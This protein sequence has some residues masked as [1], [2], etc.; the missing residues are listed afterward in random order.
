MQLPKQTNT[1]DC[2]LYMLT[3]IDELLSQPLNRLSQLKII[4]N[5]IQ[6]GLFP[7]MLIFT[8]RDR[9]LRLI[10]E[11]SSPSGQ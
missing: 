5:R 8:M 11:L 4:N 6:L 7:R 9:L 1:H 10:D 3:Y 2:G